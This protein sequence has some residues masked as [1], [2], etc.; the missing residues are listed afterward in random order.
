MDKCR[1]SAKHDK[2]QIQLITQSGVVVQ[3]EVADTW[4]TMDDAYK[5]F[6]MKVLETAQ[7]FKE[8]ESELNKSFETVKQATASR[9]DA[10]SKLRTLYNK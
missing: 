6:K 2:L 4:C 1:A 3:C 10:M 9:E 8:T 7:M 5:F